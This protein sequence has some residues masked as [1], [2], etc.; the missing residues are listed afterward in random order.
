MMKFVAFVTVYADKKND[1]G[2]AGLTGIPNHRVDPDEL[3]VKV[4]KL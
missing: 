3:T 1:F 4:R 2:I